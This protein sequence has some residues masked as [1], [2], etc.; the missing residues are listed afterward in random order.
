MALLDKAIMF[1]SLLKLLFGTKNDK[2]LKSYAGMVNAI[3]G[4][5]AACSDKTQEEIQQ[6]IVQLKDLYQTK[7]DLN[8]LLPEA[9]ALTR[10]AA[11]R[12]IGQRHYDVQLLAGISLHHGNV[13]E[14]MTGE[15]AN[16]ISNPTFCVLHALTGKGVHIVTVNDYL[17]KRDAEWMGKIY[18]Y[19]GLTVGCIYSN[20]PIEDKG[21]LMRQIL[22][23]PPTMNLALTTLETI[24]PKQKILKL[25]EI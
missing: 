8:A 12:A 2:I 20:M 10:E 4:L 6:R 9:F 17:A 14:M 16:F 5:E 1:A 7:Q 3:N 23:M 22:L 21:Q 13:A 18:Q 19:L 15:R 25:K 24:W 11:K